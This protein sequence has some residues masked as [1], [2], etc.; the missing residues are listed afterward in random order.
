MLCERCQ[1]RPATIHLTEVINNHKSKIALCEVCA[2]EI[3][4]QGFGLLPPLSLPYFLAGLLGHGFNAESLEQ[5]D[6]PEIKCESCGLS[7]SQFVKRGLLGC[8]NCYR[9]FAEK[10]EP[11]LRRIQGK[12]EHVGKMPADSLKSD[13]WLKNEI[14]VM[15]KKLK[16]AI[17]AE[18]YE[19]A[20]GIRDDIRRMEKQLEQGVSGNVN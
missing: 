4:A 19:E 10:L 16:R 9:S 18:E 13:A 1:Q 17:E 8:G 3:Q 7:E 20:A 14:E 11:L 5:S 6:G 15:R 12:V 2:R